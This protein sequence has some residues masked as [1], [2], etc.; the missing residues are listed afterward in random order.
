MERSVTTGG[1]GTTAFAVLYFIELG[2]TES[3][4]VEAIDTYKRQHAGL[5]VQ[6]IASLDAILEAIRTKQF[7]TDD[8][9]K[10]REPNVHTWAPSY[11]KTVPVK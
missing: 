11:R 4:A 8:L 2:F 1:G 10:N 9:L 3:Q 5:S 7:R 6:Q